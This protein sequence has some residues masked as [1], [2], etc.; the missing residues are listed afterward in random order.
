MTIMLI[1]EKKIATAYFAKE[2]EKKKKMKNFFLDKQA[3]QLTIGNIHNHNCI[4]VS[5]GNVIKMSAAFDCA[6]QT[7]LKENE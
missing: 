2:K 3:I 4:C 1:V 7:Y 5:I 6:H